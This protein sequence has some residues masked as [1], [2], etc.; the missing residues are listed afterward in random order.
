MYVTVHFNTNVTRCLCQPAA[1]P[2]FSC[3]HHS[4]R[5]VQRR[6]QIP[7][8]PFYIFAL[9]ALQFAQSFNQLTAVLQYASTKVRR[10]PHKSTQNCQQTMTVVSTA[11]H[12]HKSMPNWA[13]THIYTCIS[14]QTHIHLRS[15]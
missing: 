11:A 1:S 9:S 13:L 10:H 7:I 5:P 2:I 12:A 8:F 3:L 15:C 14:T 6:K 4:L